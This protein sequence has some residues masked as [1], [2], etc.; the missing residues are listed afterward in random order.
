VFDERGHFQSFD[1]LK[2]KPKVKHMRG[3][4][5]GELVTGGCFDVDLEADGVFIY[6]F[7]S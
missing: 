2:L 5:K 3:I 4:G 7:I 6:L 1:G